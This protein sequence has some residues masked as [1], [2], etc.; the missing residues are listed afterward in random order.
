[1]TQTILHTE[2]QAKHAML[3]TL[4]SGSMTYRYCRW[5]GDLTVSGNLFT[6]MPS[7]TYDIEAQGG[8]TEEAKAQITM[9]AEADPVPALLTPY[10]HAP[11]TALIQEVSPGDD[12]SLRN[13]YKGTFGTI[14]ENPGGNE[15]IAQ[16]DVLGIKRRL[17][18]AVIGLPALTTCI[19]SLG[20]IRCQVDLTSDILTGTVQSVRRL[21]DNH[22]EVSL[23]GSPDMQNARWRR[24]Y[25]DVDGGRSIIR[26]VLSAGTNPSPVVELLL[27][28][29]PS[30]LWVGQSIALTPGCD[31]NLSTCRT[32]WDNES[33]FMGFGF[34]MPTRNPVFEQ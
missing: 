17:N 8:D 23:T 28:E 1:M 16:I 10:I 12:T 15:T 3:L 29:F 32:V 33:Q 9:D 7:L 27:R 31:G 14:T 25:V 26:Q 4:L 24:G 6:A 18:E 19:N 2:S 11:V 30:D 20:D 34:A 5:D 22:I 21:Y 13:V